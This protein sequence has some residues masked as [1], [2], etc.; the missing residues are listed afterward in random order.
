MTMLK[1]LGRKCIA[2]VVLI[3]LSAAFDVD[4]QRNPQMCLGNS[5]GVIRSALS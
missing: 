5:C 3:D 2:P 4:D 1:A